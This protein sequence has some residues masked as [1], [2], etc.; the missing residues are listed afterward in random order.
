MA[1]RLNMIVD[2]VLAGLLGDAEHSE[3]ARPALMLDQLCREA[4]AEKGGRFESG[5]LAIREEGGAR[6]VSTSLFTRWCGDEL[7]T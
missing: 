7:E 6:A 4:L 5:E 2:R 3:P 1:Q